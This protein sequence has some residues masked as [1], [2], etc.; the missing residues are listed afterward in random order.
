MRDASICKNCC[1]RNLVICPSA[2]GRG[3]HLSIRGIDYYVRSVCDR[4]GAGEKILPAHHVE[5]IGRLGN[6]FRTEA[7]APVDGQ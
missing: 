4:I 5:P 3:G 6:I 1:R 7:K 2:V